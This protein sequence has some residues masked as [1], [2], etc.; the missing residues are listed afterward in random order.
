MAF[1]R[2]ELLYE[3]VGRLLADEYGVTA[4]T[5]VSAGDIGAVGYFSRATI[6]DTVG[7]V[8]PAATAY[9]PVDPDIV[10]PGNNYAI[11]PRLI[12]DAQPE[13][14]VIVESYGRLGL[15]QDRDFNAQYEQI[16]KLGTD[17]YGSRGMLV[18]RRSS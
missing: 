8:T 14:L 9:Y 12:L 17:I 4:D 6:F 13:F 15:M 16:V 5:V 18:F 3:R 10:A 2:L 1:I 11:P 7:L